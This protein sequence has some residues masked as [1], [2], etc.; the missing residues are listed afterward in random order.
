[1][2]SLAAF[3]GADFKSPSRLDYSNFLRATHFCTNDIR[4]KVIAFKRFIFNVFLI[5]EIIIVKTFHSLC[6]KMDNGNLPPA[7]DVTFSIV[8]SNTCT[9]RNIRLL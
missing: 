5:I 1:M 3:T 7:Y 4:G 6:P 8:E 2:Q 9:P